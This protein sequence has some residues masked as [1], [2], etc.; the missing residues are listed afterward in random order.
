MAIS[1]SFMHYFIHLGKKVHIWLFFFLKQ[2]TSFTFTCFL[3]IVT[4]NFGQYH[5]KCVCYD[6]LI[7]MCRQM[8]W[9][10]HITWYVCISFFMITLVPF[11]LVFS[12]AYTLV[13]FWMS[14]MKNSMHFILC[15]IYLFPFSHLIMNVSGK[16]ILK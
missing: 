6:S 13:I 7:E 5:T 2:T 11:A 8:P 4:S 1:F 10:N 9:W 14:A 12:G 16:R 3:T 15:K